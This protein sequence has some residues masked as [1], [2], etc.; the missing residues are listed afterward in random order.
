MST[1]KGVQKLICKK[2]TKKVYESKKKEYE[3]NYSIVSL[4]IMNNKKK[5]V[6]K[7]RRVSSCPVYPQPCD[8][9]L[10]RYSTFK[11]LLV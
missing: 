7:M 4:A 9:S 1:K 10:C 6:L 8:L 2:E 11:N 3:S 5:S